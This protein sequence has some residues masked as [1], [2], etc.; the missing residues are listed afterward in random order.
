MVLATVPKYDK[1]GNFSG[2]DF[3]ILLAQDVGGAINGAG[4]VDVYSG[5]GTKGKIKASMRH[6]YGNMWI[7]LPKENNQLAM[8]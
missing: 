2:H 5:T 6:H 3:K 1:K 4:H 7:L 8:K